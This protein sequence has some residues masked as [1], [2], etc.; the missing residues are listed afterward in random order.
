MPARGVGD[1]LDA[2]AE[3]AHLVHEGGQVSTIPL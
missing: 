1:E 2:G 3:E